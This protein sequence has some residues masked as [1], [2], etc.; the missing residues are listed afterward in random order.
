MN[1]DFLFRVDASLEIGSGHVMRCLALANELALYGRKSTFVTHLFEG[2]LVAQIRACGHE[3]LALEEK[4]LAADSHHDAF[5]ASCLPINWS[6]D[7]LATKNLVFERVFDWLV[8]DHYSLDIKWETALRDHAHKT[9]VIDDLANRRHSCN[10]ILDQN[11]GRKLNDY[12]G[13]LDVG[14]EILLG[15]HYALL[16]PEFAQN[17]DRSLARRG[18]NRMLDFLVSMGGVDQENITGRIL[19]TLDS[20]DMPF[21]TSI[22]VVLGA[23][24]PWINEVT[25]QAKAIRHKTIVY[26][27]V[28]NMAELLAKSDVAIGAAGSSSWER[29]AMGVPSVLFELADNQKEVIQAL[30][31]VG[32][33][34]TASLE[35]LETH[36]IFADLLTEM[37]KSLKS[38]SKNAANICDGA[39]C[40]RTIQ[41]LLRAQ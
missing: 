27:N 29:C 41:K 8:V 36:G 32:A 21:E 28:S 5:G 24:S 37:G 11:L 2:H 33:A 30:E 6:T 34:K 35:D 25:K 31:I 40:S 1:S 16:R 4:Y 14:T 20:I 26:T 3:V 23:S 13:L 10:L 38:I 39:G 12:D 15:P 22:R 9:L 19:N 18:T 7:S 17:R